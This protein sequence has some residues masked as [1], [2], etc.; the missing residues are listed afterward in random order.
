MSW[1]GESPTRLPRLLVL[2]D[3]TMLPAGQ[4]LTSAL[5]AAVQGGARAVVLRE[6]DLPTLVRA[7]LAHQAQ[8]LLSPVGGILLFA[9]AAPPA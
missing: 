9:S 1:R 5:R 2:T 6:R 8:A 7:R 3:R 4:D